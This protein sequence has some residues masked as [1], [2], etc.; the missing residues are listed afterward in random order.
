MISDRSKLYSVEARGYSHNIGMARNLLPVSWRRRLPS[1]V[2]RALMKAYWLA[3]DSR[4]FVAEA[5]GWVP[6]HG[7]RLSLYRYLVRIKIGKNTSVHRGCRIYCPTGVRIG[8]H[9]IINRDVLLDGRMGVDIGDNVSVSEGVMILSLEHDLGS[10][11][12]SN[13]GGVVK[14]CDYAFIGA[15]AIVLPGVV[16]GR[17]AAVG[18]GAVVTRDVEEL[19]IVAGVPARP[20]GKRPDALT[21]SLNYR[22]FL[23]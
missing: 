3:Y 21:Y 20:I 16:I 19:T 13:R 1:G 22:K 15:R 11:E 5:I 4:D 17:G 12:F 10:P 23:G 18:A 14:I 8:Q 2:K 7:L 6:F 9:T